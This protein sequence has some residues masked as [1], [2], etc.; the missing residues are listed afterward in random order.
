MGNVPPGNVPCFTKMGNVIENLWNPSEMDGNSL[1]TSETVRNELKIPDNLR[2][3]TLLI[4][5]NVTV[6]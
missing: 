4:H 5:S 6:G 2:Q 1:K 3:H